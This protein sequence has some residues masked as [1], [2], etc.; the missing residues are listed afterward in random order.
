MID[1]GKTPDVL[2]TASQEQELIL[3]GTVLKLYVGRTMVYLSTCLPG[4]DSFACVRNK[5]GVP[6]LTR[7][8]LAELIRSKQ[9][10]IS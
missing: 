1:L 10:V 2:L 7:Q 3:D 4:Q 6:L 5:H 8:E 9:Y